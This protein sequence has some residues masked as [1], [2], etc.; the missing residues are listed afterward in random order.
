MGSVSGM[1][2]LN[3]NIV[4]SESKRPSQS[5]FLSPY[6]RPWC[7][8]SQ[9]NLIVEADASADYYV[10]A[11]LAAVLSWDANHALGWASLHGFLSWIYV[12]YYAVTRWTA[13]KMF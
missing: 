9:I 13:T 7:L 6:I 12:I 8:K 1:T 5:L 11:A 4:Y 10:G 2:E 3:T